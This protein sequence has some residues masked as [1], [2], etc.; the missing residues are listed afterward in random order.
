MAGELALATR[1]REP[2]PAVRP[3][4]DQAQGH[5]E[6]VEGVERGPVRVEVGLGPGGR[7]LDPVERLGKELRGDGQVRDGQRDVVAVEP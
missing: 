7:I 4:L 3:R 1:T 6:L 2:M 5:H